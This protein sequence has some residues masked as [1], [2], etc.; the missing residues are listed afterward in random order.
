MTIQWPPAITESVHH[1]V[2]RIEIADCIES[3]FAD[4]PISSDELIAAATQASARPAV[5][6][7]LAT[8][9]NR[10]YHRLVD[11]W[12]HL[13]DLPISVDR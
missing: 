11:L 5:L 3:A 7:A 10:R 4:S 6:D 9:P 1:P 8:L 13:A 12:T 2:S